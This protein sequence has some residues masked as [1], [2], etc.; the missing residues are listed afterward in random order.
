[1]IPARLAFDPAAAQTAVDRDRQDAGATH[2]R[3]GDA[4]RAAQR[5]C[6]AADHE[7]IAA[8][9]RSFGGDVRMTSPIAPVAPIGWPR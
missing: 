5:L 3:G 6:V 8:A 9:V 1:V 2:V 4:R 7:E